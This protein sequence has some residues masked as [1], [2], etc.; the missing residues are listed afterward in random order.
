LADDGSS[1]DADRFAYLLKVGEKVM[2]I[3]G[4]SSVGFKEP[5]T[6][7]ILWVNTNAQIGA[8]LNY[9]LSAE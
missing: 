6:C 1:Q 8:P 9:Y 2:V 3:F 5:R 4:D 7:P